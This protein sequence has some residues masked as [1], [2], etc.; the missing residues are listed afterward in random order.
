MASWTQAKIKT[1]ENGEI[2]LKFHPD[3]GQFLADPFST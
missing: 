2:G 1:F 3:V